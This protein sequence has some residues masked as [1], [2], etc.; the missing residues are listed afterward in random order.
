LIQFYLYARSGENFEIRDMEM[1]VEFLVIVEVLCS[2]CSIV[3]K[4][5]YPIPVEF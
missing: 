3:T 5:E 4:R 1:N 2:S